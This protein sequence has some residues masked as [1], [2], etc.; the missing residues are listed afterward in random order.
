[1]V[2]RLAAQEF[3]S[4]VQNKALRSISYESSSL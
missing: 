2:H 1:V 4:F 3:I